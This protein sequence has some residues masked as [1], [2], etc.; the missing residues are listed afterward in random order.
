MEHKDLVPLKWPDG[1]SRTLIDQRQSRSAW[2][3]PFSYYRE[4]V[5]KEL[6]RVGASA[7]T[8]SRN[9]P[10]KER[11][12]PGVAVWFSLKPAEDFSWQAGL[13]LDNPAPSLDEIDR[14]YRTLAQRHHPD[15]VSAGSGGDVAMFHRL[16][17]YRK[18]A[19]AWVLGTD[20]PP[21]DNCIP[22]DRFV[23]TQQN[24]AAIRLAL[25]AFRQLERVGIPAI[26]ERV[27]DRAFKAALP[28]APTTG[29]QS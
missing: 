10:A 15:A 28:G 24:L 5:L 19:R 3:K 27:M 8:I 1:W 21:L 12:D 7:V 29:G 22:C 4:Q 20:A 6:V 25:A 18:R 16:S 26:L 23:S 11:V 13:H 14:A 2:K 17:E 9:E